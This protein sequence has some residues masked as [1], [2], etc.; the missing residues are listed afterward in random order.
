MNL[1]IQNFSV[2]FQNIHGLHGPL[3][4]KTRD[5]EKELKNDIEIW[6]E[7]WGCEC[8]LEF[9]DYSFEIMEPQKHLGI[10]KGRKSGGFVILAK[11]YMEKMF[12]IIKKSNNFV[13]IEISKNVIKNAKE[14]LFIVATYV[15]DITST[16]YNEEIFE[17]LENDI[18]NFSNDS[19]PILVMGDFN[20]RTGLLRDI[21]EEDKAFF[22]GPQLKTKF[23]DIPIR[24]NCDRIENSHGKKIINF[25]KT[26]D[27]M[28]LNGRTPGDPFGN[29]THL[30]FNNG[31]STIDY[32]L[33]NEKCFSFIDNFLVLPMNE[34]SDH[35][36]IVTVFKDG[37]NE[38]RDP[39]NDTYA[40]KPRGALFKWDKKRK[41]N[42]VNKLKNSLKEIGDIQQRIDAGLVHSTG[43]QIQ[44]LF[45]KTAT[46]ILQEKNKKVSKNW[47]KRKK[48]K[49]WF[50]NE[51]RDFQKVVRKLGKEKH[52]TPNSN[53]LLEK[54]HLKLKEFKKTCKSKKHFFF[55]ESLNEIE[56]AL[57][58][59]KLFWEKWK[60]FGEYERTEKETKIP[61]EKLYSYFSNLHNETSQDNVIGLEPL[62]I[63]FRSKEKLNKP[64]SK[65]EF[66]NVIETL[67]TGKSE[68][69]DSICNEM[70]ISSPDVILELL[71]N[72]MNIC[73]EKSMV[74]D[75]WIFELISLIHKK[76]NQTDL[77]NYR[78]ICVSS[79]LLKILCSLLNNR[80]QLFCTENGLIN[81]N[82][83]GFQKNCRTTDHIFTLKTLVKKYVTIGEEKLFTCFVDFQKAF[84]SVW[85]K[86]LFHKL[87]NNG[88]SGKSLS[89]IFNLYSKT[90]C[91][92]KG[93]N[94][95]TDFFRYS[96]GVRQGC[97]LS[98]ILFNLYV[99]DLFNII[100][101]NSTP[102]V[103]LKESNKINALMYADD[104][105]LISRSKEG[106]QR[107]IDALQEYCQKWKLDINIK[108]T[109]TM[110]FNRGNKII[111]AD[112]NV[113][114][115]KIENVKSFTY[116]GFTISAK[117]CSF[118]SVMDDLSVK[119]N[120]AI[121]ALKNK[122][123]LSRLPVKLAIK[124][125]K[126]QIVPILLYGS[127][128]WGP[129]M[130]LDYCTWDKTATERVQTQFLKRVLGCNLQT[131]NNM[132]RA[133]TG[134]RPLITIIIQRFI[135]YFKSVQNRKSNLCYDAFIFETENSVSPNFGK[136]AENFNLDITNLTSISKEKIHKICVGSYDRFWKTTI[137]ESSKAYS[138]NKFK[139][140]IALE[141]YL[142]LHLNLKY[143][144]AISR[145]RL[146]NHTLMIEKG[147]HHKPKKIDKKERK[148]YFCKN[149]IENEEHFM[150]ECPLYAPL[151]II[152][153]NICSDMYPRYNNLTGEQK[154]IFV[155][156]NENEKIIRALGKYISE[157]FILRDKM[158]NYFSF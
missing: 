108:K 103:Y 68:G 23:E 88:I 100:D 95:I 136:F 41:N 78:G 126:S 47:K 13:W 82:Q 99:N 127:E 131:S 19:T 30:N 115:V 142:D 56:S 25:C 156:S 76:G 158:T 67:K 80:I 53:L 144:I 113:A 81:K 123:K 5:L 55:R 96:K 120:K 35:S 52:A 145:F 32:A 112:F 137:S 50:D 134:C 152:F 130:N 14:N 48:S 116:L 3:G 27:F 21:F 46:A 51:C 121:F 141:P 128:V 122:I 36:K 73:L 107:Q 110:I 133:D 8:K 124:I 44:Q 11:H 42:F 85:H 140:N 37:M 114:G 118:Q 146:C 119:A 66:K 29:F 17:E 4:C 94:G 34:L 18:H 43:K 22:P 70:I 33:C 57:S 92:I 24:K 7:I 54:Y 64:F 102:D 38:K 157:S 139:T 105:V 101:Q 72:F 125:F 109:K 77:G 150:I 40:W 151:R 86:G 71:N 148:C 138:F 74:P 2:G 65:K 31:P 39:E 49:K 69:Y 75:S 20:G 93:N 111:K 153:E 58:D 155:M 132:A 62:H 91:A 63:E 104:L 26:L 6:C 143:Q 59:S 61:G 135:S 90:Q 154:F 106:L 60:K 147:R 16:Y 1:N 83:I 28:I 97:P 149:K 15:N 84:D 10:T 87:Y 79:A 89:L 9:D 117:N 12:K 45:I 98:P 129:Y